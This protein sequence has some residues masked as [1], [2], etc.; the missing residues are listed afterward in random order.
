MVAE[1][2]TALARSLTLIFFVPFK[3][4][5][6]RSQKPEARNLSSVVCPLSP[7]TMILKTKQDSGSRKLANSEL[8]QSG[9][10]IKPKQ[11]KQQVFLQY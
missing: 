5:D 4:S 10:V 11:G 1:G 3:K 2:G 8:K 9:L 7:P 6:V